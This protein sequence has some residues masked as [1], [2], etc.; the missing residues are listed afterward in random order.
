MDKL[1]KVN[2]VA[3]NESG[4]SQDEMTNSDL[5]TSAWHIAHIKKGLRQADV[6]QFASEK[7]VKTVFKRLRR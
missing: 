2:L 7:D 5:E 6:G 3:E 4:K 1:F